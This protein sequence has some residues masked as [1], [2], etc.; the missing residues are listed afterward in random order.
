VIDHGIGISEEQSEHLFK[1]FE[2][3][4]G[5]ITRTYGG[6]GLGLSISKSLVELMGGRIKLSSRLGEG[7]TF[8]FTISCQGRIKPAGAGYTETPDNSGI[9]PDEKMGFGGKRCLVVDDIEINREIVIELLSDT[10]MILET[11]VN[12]QEAVDKFSA[13]S[14][15]YYDLILM[16]MQMPVM[17][18]CT[19]SREIRAL[20]AERFGDNHVSIIAMTANVMEEDI[21]KTAEAGMDA[22]LGKPIDV[23]ALYKKMRKE[24]TARAVL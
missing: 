19:A 16:D 3:S 9:D 15:G 22:H 23:K 21:R 17:D 4:D 14:P 2:Q 11:A 5:S 20:E 18:G 6:A 10:G 7:S 1:P 12:G 8:S 24:F 13:A